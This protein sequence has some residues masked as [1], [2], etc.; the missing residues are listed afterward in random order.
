MAEPKPLPKGFQAK[1]H[2]SK[3][4]RANALTYG[5]QHNLQIKRIIKG[6]DEER[7]DFENRVDESRKKA[8]AEEK[9]RD[10]KRKEWNQLNNLKISRKKELDLGG[11]MAKILIWPKFYAN[12]AVF[13]I[14]PIFSLFL[15]S[16]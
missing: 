15:E 6:W 7:N 11:F 8:E 2:K 5:K 1:I 4:P 13:I 3:Q 10:L 14:F 16:A 12:L 9:N